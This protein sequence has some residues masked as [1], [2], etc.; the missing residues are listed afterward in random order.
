[1]PT[2]YHMQKGGSVLSACGLFPK[3][4]I[5]RTVQNLHLVLTPPSSTTLH[6]PT[7]K[8]ALRSRSSPGVC[9]ATQPAFKPGLAVPLLRFLSVIT[10]LYFTLRFSA[11][12][13]PPFTSKEHSRFAECPRVDAQPPFVLCGLWLRWP[14]PLYPPPLSPPQFFVL[15][16]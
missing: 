4:A 3:T 12:I 2:G 10:L 14:H 15:F 6:H 13:R 11:H 5:F 8:R 9:S 1:M 7:N 16:V